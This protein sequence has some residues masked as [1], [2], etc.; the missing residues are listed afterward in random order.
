MVILKKSNRRSFET[1]NMIWRGC[2]TWDLHDFAISY[3]IIWSDR[4]NSTVSK[5][6]FQKL[7]FS[8][9]QSC[10]KPVWPT[11]HT[12]L[13]NKTY[14]KHRPPFHNPRLKGN[15]Y[16]EKKL[17]LFLLKYS[18]LLHPQEKNC[19]E[20]K[21]RKGLNNRVQILVDMVADTQADTGCLL[22][23]YQHLSVPQD[24]AEK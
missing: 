5:G 17:H 15:E 16:L 12:Y 14:P 2:D 11:A 22:G 20:N 4:F 3:S 9:T 6:E 13:I 7:A 18:I 19:A 21:T 1:L 10:W 24:Q 8:K 23:F